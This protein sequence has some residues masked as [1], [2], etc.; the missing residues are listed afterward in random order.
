M[1]PAKNKLPPGPDRPAPR[2]SVCVPIYN[3]AIHLRECLSSI[4]QQTLPDFEVVLV[5][6]G[7]TDASFEIAA[8]FA[9]DDSRFQVHRNARRLGL[10]GNWGRCVELARAEWIKFAFQDDLL[11]PACLDRLLGACQHHNKRFGFC[12]R[13][14]IFEDGVNPSLRGW[15]QN[16]A[17]RLSR[18]Y[19]AAAVIDAGQAARIIVAEPAHNP[20]GEPTVTLIHKSLFHELGGFD[21]AFIQL[22]DSEFWQRIMVNYGAV[23][24]PDE[25]AVFRIHAGATTAVNHEKRAFRMGFLDPLVLRHRY[26]FGR[27]FQALRQ[28]AAG[29]QGAWA[30]RWQ[31]AL[32]AARAWRQAGTDPACLAE[33]QAVKAHCPSLQALARVGLVL[34]IPGRI[35]QACLQK[36]PAKTPK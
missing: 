15:F 34:E 29:G 19:Q 6:D 1:N 32:A 16:H 33:W 22:C 13:S 2:V 18:D 31:C 36:S 12:A 25:L 3:G 21:D 4:R 26:A 10:V 20:V 24:V 14:F 35:K 5:D 11:R 7:S 23:F 30:L 9:R 8:E 28:S 27:H 17:A